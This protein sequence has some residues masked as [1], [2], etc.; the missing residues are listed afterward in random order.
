VRPGTASSSRGEGG[1]ITAADLTDSQAGVGETA[2]APDSEEP[3]TPSPP[4]TGVEIWDPDGPDESGCQPGDGCFGEA[5]GDAEDC[6]SGICAM[7]MGDR[8][9]SKTCDAAC[10]DGFSCQLAAGST[11]GQSVCVSDYPH[12]CLPC[13][14]SEGCGADTPQACVRYPNGLS[15][16][17]GA[18]D[19]EVPCPGGYDCQQVENTAGVETFQCVATAGVCTCS[20]VAIDM[21]LSTPCRQENEF[22][23][24][25]GVAA[26]TIASPPGPP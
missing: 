22:G 3:D 5:C 16:C 12:L 11:D 24:C 8:I 26:C 14:T 7:H 1:D 18:C 4:D 13:E 21:G 17:G 9:C 15:F 20:E 19:L 6:L 10:P 25:D 23:S 2:V